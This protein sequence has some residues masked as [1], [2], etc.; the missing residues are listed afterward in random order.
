MFLA[1]G[2]LLTLIKPFLQISQP[3][4]NKKTNTSKFKP[5]HWY[6]KTISF[7][8]IP[9]LFVHLNLI[10]QEYF[11]DHLVDDNVSPLA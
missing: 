8:K 6:S 7:L 4:D 9:S 10:K 5:V 1:F 11:S 2:S 3:N